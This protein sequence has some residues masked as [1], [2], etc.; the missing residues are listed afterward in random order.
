MLTAGMGCLQSLAPNEREDTTNQKAIRYRRLHEL[1]VPFL[2]IDQSS[3]TST[4]PHGAA[5]WSNGT[6]T[7]QTESANCAAIKRAHQRWYWLF[8]CLKPPRAFAPSWW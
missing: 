8:C 7:A 6:P 1:G 4:I 3:F 2:M 5:P